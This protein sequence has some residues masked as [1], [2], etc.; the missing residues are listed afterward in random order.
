MPSTIHKRPSHSRS[1]IPGFGLTLGYTMIYLSLIVLVPLAGVLVEAAG[2]GLDGLWPI[3]GS[4]RV[5]SALK[6]SFGTALIA[7]AV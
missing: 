4:P 2:L 5:L 3:L 7:A 6:L 1:P